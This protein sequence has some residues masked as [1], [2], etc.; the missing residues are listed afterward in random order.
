MPWQKG[1]ANTK[2]RHGMTNTPIYKAWNNMLSR[3][4]NP[5]HPRYKDWGGR[6]ITVTKSWLDFENFYKDM[7]DKP[8]PKHTLERKDNE[9]GYDKDNCVWATTKEQATNRRS[10]KILTA[11]GYQFTLVEFAEKFSINK[12]TLGSRLRRGWTLEEALMGKRNV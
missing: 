9:R 12:I 7:G 5:N 11:N 1:A 8:S 2:Y 6:G 4:L 10:N 3:C